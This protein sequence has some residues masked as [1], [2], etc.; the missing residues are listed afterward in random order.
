VGDPISV[1]GAGEVAGEGNLCGTKALLGQ[2]LQWDSGISHAGEGRATALE[3]EFH[4][5]FILWSRT[6]HS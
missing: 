1:L 2:K 6:T 3:T 5:Q 4:A